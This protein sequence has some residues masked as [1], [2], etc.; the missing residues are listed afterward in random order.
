MEENKDY[1]KLARRFSIALENIDAAYA[2]SSKINSISDS[3]LCFMYSLDD[4]EMHSQKEISEMWLIPKTTISSIVSRWEKEGF[5][6]KTPIPGK[7]RETNLSLTEAGKEHSKKFLAFL[8]MAEEK[9]IKETIERYSD[10]FI[11]AV[12]YFGERI[13][14]AFDESL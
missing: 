7:R 12:E 9:A 11:E 13:K 8:Y 2:L 1:K 3:E 5:L 6:I 14:K 4:G 10:V